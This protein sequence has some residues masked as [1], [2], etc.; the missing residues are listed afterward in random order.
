M[1][2]GLVLVVV[3]ALALPGG[4][5]SPIT[6]SA[7]GA[8]KT[9]SGSGTSSATGAPTPTVGGAN[10]LSGFPAP[11]V[12]TTSS[13]PTV[14]NTSTGT[15]GSS[16]FSSTSALIIVIGAVLILG[17]ISFFIWR[18]ARR[19]APVRETA[20]VPGGDGRSKPGSKSAPKPRKLSPA[21]RRR[22]KRGRAKR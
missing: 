1:R 16:S 10:G 4:V 17:G 15:A 6:A 2:R 7:A 14:L 5:L 21:E 12:V 22:R 19:R 18:D 11:P 3:M 13:T 9:S 8:K 20:G